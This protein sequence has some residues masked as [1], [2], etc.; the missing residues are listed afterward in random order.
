MQFIEKPDISLKPVTVAVV[1]QQI[2]HFINTLTPRIKMDFYLDNKVKHMILIFENNP[3]NIVYNRLLL[4]RLKALNITIPVMRYEGMKSN[5]AQKS[6][7]FS[8]LNT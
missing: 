1:E 3:D 6:Y 2:T 5:P 7:L 4:D 8:I